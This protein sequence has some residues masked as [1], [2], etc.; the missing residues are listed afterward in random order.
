MTDAQSIGEQFR[1]LAND[2]P[3]GALRQITEELADIQ[4]K[5]LQLLGNG[6]PAASDFGQAIAARTHE[7]TG[8]IQSFTALQSD[9]ETIGDRIAGRG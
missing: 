7:L 2:V 6:H 3:V 1:L 8:I 5:G 4:L 9:I